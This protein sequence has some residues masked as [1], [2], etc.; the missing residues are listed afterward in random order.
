M[1]KN[2]GN[3]RVTQM[4]DG[5]Q[6]VE[7]TLTPQQIVDMM[8]KFAVHMMGEGNMEADEVKEALVQMTG[9]QEILADLIDQAV[10]KA[11]KI[12]EKPV[13]ANLS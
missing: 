9:S 11:E 1:K 10:E 8:E 13:S 5:R 4:D 7:I 12:T 6:M 2:P 3:V